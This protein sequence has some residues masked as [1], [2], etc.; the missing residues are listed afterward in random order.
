MNNISKIIDYIKVHHTRTLIDGVLY[1]RY[2]VNDNKRLGIPNG[3]SFYRKSPSATYV[4]LT[5]TPAVSGMMIRYS[6]KESQIQALLKLIVVKS[7]QQDTRATADLRANKR[8]APKQGINIE[9]PTG[10]CVVPRTINSNTYNRVV[11][12]IFNLKK[13]KFT[14]V[15]IHAGRV[16][17]EPKLQEALNKAIEMRKSS[18]ALAASL[19]QVNAPKVV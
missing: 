8:S 12:N 4:R 19:T 9:L 7:L 13:N 18:L 11:V 3:I 16:G 2:F 5:S 17:N 10:V 6:C 1:P 15:H 14:P